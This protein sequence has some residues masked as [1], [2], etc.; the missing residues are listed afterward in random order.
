MTNQEEDKEESL[1]EIRYGYRMVEKREVVMMWV[2]K[3][4]KG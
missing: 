1:G 2:C 4:H 3:A